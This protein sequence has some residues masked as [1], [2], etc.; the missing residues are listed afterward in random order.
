MRDKKVM[1]VLGTR[2]EAIKMCPL[3][4]ELRS[5]QGLQTI[6]CLTGQHRDMVTQTLEF[7]GVKA[8]YDLGVM[9]ERQSLFDITNGVLGGLE[10]LLEYERP[11]M[12]LVH[13]DTPTA[14]C[15]ALA[16]YYKR[17]PVGHV[18]AGLRTYDAYAPYPEEFNRS[19]IGI[20]AG[21]HFAPTP[22]A[23]ENLL[24][25]GRRAGGIF[26]TGNTVIDAMKETVQP[27]YTDENL[28]WARSGRLVLLTAHRRENL[29]RRH[30]GI[31][32]AI[33]R[34]MDETPDAY[35]IF[36]VH[37]NPAVREQLAILSRCERVRLIEPLDVQRFHN[38]LAR[39]HLVL[40]DSG[41]VQ[42]EAS[43][44]GK[45]TLVLRDITERPEGVQAGTLKLAG[46]QEESVYRAFRLLMDDPAEYARMSTGAGNPYGDGS[47]AARIADIIVRYLR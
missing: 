6:L 23:R 21:L 12:L 14:F 22:W 19:A 42:E 40:T 16:A 33:R 37:P 45:P 46:T 28:R 44:L 25:E 1:A 17:I 5:R 24:R 10:P 47:A 31:F 41:G 11:D 39:A 27:D 9:K 4:K 15:A 43:G 8:Q 3:I 13:G 26:V 32:R 20:I 36:P 34:V 2:P 35:L 30:A 29:G 38:Y 7:F 18:E